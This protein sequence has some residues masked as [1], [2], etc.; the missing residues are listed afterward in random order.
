[1]P[2]IEKEFEKKVSSK[3]LSDSQVIALAKS[4]HT[5]IVE[6]DYATN[7]KYCQMSRINT[8]IK[9]LYPQ[10]YVTIST[11]NKPDRA[12]KQAEIKKRYE[13]NVKRLENR[14]EFTYKEVTKAITTLKDSEDYY[15]LVV[16]ILLSSGRRATEVIARGKFEP[17]HLKHH[18]IF[19]GQLKTKEEKRDAYDIPVVGMTPENLIEIVEK[20]RTLKDY[21]DKSNEFIASRTNAYINKAIANIFDKDRHVTSETLR[22]IYAYIAYR[23]YGNPQISETLYG[24]KILGHKEGNLNTFAVNYNRVF[25]KGVPNTKKIC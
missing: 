25:V 11:F 14:Q 9:K 20:I 10:L 12:E 6:S 1:M 2:P 15:K 23:L 21:Q 4:F 16:C 7:S 24:S 3:K 5:R 8:V 13:F 19:S 18:V 17:S 22:C